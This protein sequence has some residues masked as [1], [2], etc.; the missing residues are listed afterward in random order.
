MPDFIYPKD[1]FQ[2]ESES[3]DTALCFVLMP[4]A[5]EYRQVYDGAL[6]PIV[7]SAGLRCL[8]ADDLY[9]PRPILVSVMEHIAK[10]GLIIADLSGRNPN[11]FYELGI[12]H[13]RKE[14]R[15]VIL[16]AQTMEDVPFDLRHLRRI[17]Y[18]STPEG[19]EQLSRDLANTLV[20]LELASRD[21]VESLLASSESFSTEVSAVESDV[22]SYPIRGVDWND[23]EVVFNDVDESFDTFKGRFAASLVTWF[24]YA[25]IEF[26][27]SELEF[28]GGGV[29][30]RQKWPDEKS[31]RLYIDREAKDKFDDLIR[32]VRL[33]YSEISYSVPI[34]FDAGRWV[35]YLKSIALNMTFISERRVTISP[36]AELGRGFIDIEP[37]GD[38]RTLVKI[39][40][41]EGGGFSPATGTIPFEEIESLLVGEQSPDSFAESIHRHQLG[42]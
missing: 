5:G 9:S 35:G 20:S 16:I 40:S 7:E 6:K 18:K 25:D 10:A 30:H 41:R 37:D 14:N 27:D 1:Y 19:L 13:V 34:P 17:T 33:I 39:R 24:N 22:Q 29:E 8:R 26:S 28:P 11:V 23:A 31:L 4:F 15:Q 36:D 42:R 3:E 21:E 32:A 38:D 12:A 2:A